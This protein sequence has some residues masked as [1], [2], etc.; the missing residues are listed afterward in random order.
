MD[1]ITYDDFSKVEF[2][3]GEIIKAEVVGGSEKLIREV[4]DFGSYGQK[5]VFSGIRKFYQPEELLGKKTVF[6]VNMEP[7]KIMEEWSEA[8]IFGAEAE[9][10]SQLSIL[11][12]DREMANG[13]KVF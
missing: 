7:K 12:L 5:V 3:I 11:V 2:R 13:T 10:K 9:D 8:M 1:K 4:V 6:V